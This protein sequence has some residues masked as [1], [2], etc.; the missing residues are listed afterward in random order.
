MDKTWTKT[1]KQRNFRGQSN[2]VNS[3]NVKTGQVR[4]WD[5]HLT[6]IPYLL[7]QSKRKP[8]FL[9]RHKVG[10]IH[11]APSQLYRAKV[12]WEFEPQPISKTS[13]LPPSCFNGGPMT[14]PGTPTVVS[15][16]FS[17]SD[18][19]RYLD[20]SPLFQVKPFFNVKWAYSWCQDSFYWVIR[21]S[22]HWETMFMLNSY[23]DRNY[24]LG[25]LLDSFQETDLFLRKGL[26]FKTFSLKSNSSRLKL[27]YE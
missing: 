26:D 14:N 15:S 22:C 12:K 20:A 7:C 19:C 5:F 25:M 17:V 6:P 11:W 27:I 24:Y 23:M 9:R 10:T 18:W 4:S 13:E 8:K 1:I 16:L 2:L 3:K 21:C